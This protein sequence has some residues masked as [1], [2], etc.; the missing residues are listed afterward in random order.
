MLLG[1]D[2]DMAVAPAA[3]I[4]ELLYLAV[5]VLD[6]VFDGKAGRVEDADVTTKSK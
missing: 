6:V 5:I 4:T 2:P 1:R 3:E